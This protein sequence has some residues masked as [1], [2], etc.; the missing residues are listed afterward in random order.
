MPKDE[1]IKI[2]DVNQYGDLVCPHCKTNIM[3][4]A[5][6][7][8]IPGIG[9]CEICGRDFEVTDDVALEANSRRT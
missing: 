8:V 4:P 1:I 3:T 7:E 9:K 2:A 6:F 5:L